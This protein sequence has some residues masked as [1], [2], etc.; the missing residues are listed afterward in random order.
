MPLVILQSD[1]IAFVANEVQINFTLLSYG[2][3]CV[4]NNIQSAEISKL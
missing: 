4:V 3:A 1:V 2:D